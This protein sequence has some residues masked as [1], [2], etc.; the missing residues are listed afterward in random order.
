MEKRTLVAEGPVKGFPGV[1]RAGPFLFVSGCDGHRDLG[2]NQIVPALAAD[3]ERQ[4]ENAYGRLKNLLVEAGADLASVVRLDHMTS[5]QDWLPRRQVLRAKYFGQPAPLASTG[6]AAR[7][8]GINMITSYV[9]AVA[10]PADKEVLVQGAPFGMRNISA[11]VKGGPLV[12]LSGLRGNRDPRTNTPVA[13]ET[14]DA[15]GAQTRMVY[16]IMK[17]ILSECGLTPADL[18][19]LDCFIRDPARIDDDARI[20]T[21]MLGPIQCANTIV[22]LPLSARGETEITALAAAPGVKKTVIAADEN[23]PPSVVSAGGFH[24]VGAC[25]GHRG[26]SDACTD[27]ALLG[28]PRAQLDRAIADLED[29]LKRC[30]SRLDRVLRLEVYL[31]NIYF[32]D[33]ACEIL[34]GRFGASPPVISL[35]GADLEDLLEV[36]LN[37]IAC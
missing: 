36:K 24:F 22:A 10:D 25:H 6:V 2:S 12:F 5:S 29:R 15:F 7:L 23:G 18:I 33:E 4:C 31:R 8:S 16:D 35:V 14:A 9:I 19:Q 28:N 26:S 30:G 21:A 3:V 20:R 32:A 37:A 11:A 34:R 17:A 13:E 27:R 1:V